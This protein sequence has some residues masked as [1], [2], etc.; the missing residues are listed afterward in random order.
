MPLCKATVGKLKQSA[1]SF[2]QTL[3]TKAAMQRDMHH[4]LQRSTKNHDQKHSEKATIDRFFSVDQ[5]HCSV[6]FR[7]NYFESGFWVEF[8]ISSDITNITMEIR[9]CECQKP[10]CHYRWIPRTKTVTEP[11]ECPSCKH[12]FNSRTWSIKAKCWIETVNNVD[13][14]KKLKQSIKKWNYEGRFINY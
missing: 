3:K 1:L 10:L 5:T 11:I 8:L 13:E 6:D 14:L 4:R 2:Y 12:Q 9:V 7:N